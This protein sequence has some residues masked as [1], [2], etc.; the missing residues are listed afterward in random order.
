MLEMAGEKARYIPEALYVYNTINPL[1]VN[2]TRAEKQH[3]LMLEIRNKKP[4]NRLSL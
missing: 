1:A 4:Y 3:K 2:K